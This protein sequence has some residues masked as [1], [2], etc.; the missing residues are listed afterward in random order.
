MFRQIRQDQPALAARQ[1][2]T[3]QPGQKAQQHAAVFVVHGALDRRAGPRWQ[4]RWVAHHQVRLA[5]REQV[6]LHHLYLCRQAQL[7]Q[8][9]PGAGQCPGVL[10]GCHHLGYTAPGQ[11]RRQ[12]A[13]AGADI[14][15]KQGL[16]QRRRQGSV[17]HQVHVLAPQ[18]RKHAVMGVHPV[19]GR[20]PQSLDFHAFFAPLKGAGHAQQVTQ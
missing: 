13:A 8:V 11:H 20:R 3:R 4:P 7:G 15:G 2:V 6:R 19:G 10:V 18:R 9:L 17:G 16:A 12:P 1:Q 14:K 5:R